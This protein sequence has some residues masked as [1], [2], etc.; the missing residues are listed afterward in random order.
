MAGSFLAER[1]IDA[2]AKVF[3]VDDFSSGSWQNIENLKRSENFELF[4]G[5]LNQGLPAAVRQQKF[6]HIVHA[7][8]VEVYQTQDQGNLDDLLTNSL[9]TKNLLDLSLK[10]KAV[11]LL[12]SSVQVYF[13]VAGSTTLAHYYDGLE[14]GAQLSFLEAKRYAEALCR[15]YVNLYDLDI[16]IARLGEVYGPRMNL[17]S[18]TLLAKLVSLALSKKDLL[19][20]GEGSA[21]HALLYVND[22]VFGLLKLLFAPA[23]TAQQGIYDFVNPEPVSS[24]SIAYTLRDA[25][26]SPVKVEFVPEAHPPLVKKPIEPN[27]ERVRRDL[28]WEPKVDLT[29]GLKET[30]VFLEK[31][32]QQVK[33]ALAIKKEL[34]EM[35]LRLKVPEIQARVALLL[36]PANF[37]QKIISAIND[38]FLSVTKWELGRVTT[39]KGFK[40]ARFRLKGFQIKESEPLLSFLKIPPRLMLALIIIWL[41]LSP[42]WLTIL[43]GGLAIKDLRSSRSN[44]LQQNFPKVG[45]NLNSARVNFQRAQNTL[46]YA[47][48]LFA[49]MKQSQ[50]QKRLDLFLS[51]ASFGA[52]A[53]IYLNSSLQTFN[54]LL[55]NLLN[56]WPTAILTGQGK[57]SLNDEWTN[58]KVQELAQ[59]IKVDLAIAQKRWQLAL[60][61][62]ERASLL[63]WAEQALIFDRTLAITQDSLERL[64]Y[65]LGFEK[66]VRYLV[67][68]QNNAEMRATGGFVGSYLRFVLDKGAL[69]DFKVDDV[70]NPD[71]LL[72]DKEKT[73]PPAPLKE[74]LGVEFLGMRD[75]NWWPDH[76]KSAQEISRLYQLATGEE[77]EAVVF[78]NLSVIKDILQDQKGIYLDK[79]DETITAENLFEKAEYY[80]EVGFEPG[81]SKKK[82]FLANLTESLLKKLL[83]EPQ[84]FLTSAPLSLAQDFNNGEIVVYTKD[85]SLAKILSENQLDG[86]LYKTSG[87]YVMVVDSNVGGNKANYWV[88]RSLN[89]RVDVDR[90]GD[91]TG[92]VMVSYQHSGVSGTWPG[93]DYKNWFRLYLPAGA[94]L[95]ETEGFEKG[96]ENYSE[97]G[98]TVFAGLVK[99][100]VNSRKEIVV[101]YKLPPAV[102]FRNKNTYELYW[103]RQVGMGDEELHFK[104]NLPAF[105]KLSQG[106]LEWSGTLFSDQKMKIVVEKQ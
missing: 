92:V 12:T 45:Q 63:K 93:G 103:Q 40:K 47:S 15:E 17:D 11:F 2:G 14:E 61:E 86:S 76:K 35:R 16:R 32:K 39:A 9:G 69:R 60:A 106:E 97:L 31:Q 50:A 67:L 25:V 96:V 89:Y 94:Y 26:G 102:G 57:S 77:V 23:G 98:K 90:E 91:L 79:Y 99:V 74:Y 70:Y 41:L 13:G 75:A 85:L 48:P 33:S 66:P 43:F 80:S 49:L 34:K 59:Q 51:S 78:I 71:G 100:P 36:K 101:K 62:L 72:I 38:L 42:L 87:D 44:L 82:D 6:T 7:A 56:Q 53:G 24:L 73:L 58:Q 18:Q 1:L 30:F 104:M 19:V 65:L 46:S 27:L 84:P 88:K 3:G 95:L 64:N 81:S 52:E 105:L 22:A 55:Q 4:E 10:S 29:Q 8:N 28:Y 20:P 54:P 68:L 37:F 5:N 83:Q 21:E